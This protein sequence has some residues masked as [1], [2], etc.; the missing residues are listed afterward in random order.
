MPSYRVALE[1][2]DLRPGVDPAAVLP[3]VAD[4]VGE[5]ANVEAKDL[6]VAGGRAESVVRFTAADDAEA[7]AVAQHAGV[8][9]QALATT[10]PARITRRD[11]GRWTPLR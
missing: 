5:V 10:G 11:G 7:A 4:A 8:R 9:A 3:G 2:R 6:R 1:I